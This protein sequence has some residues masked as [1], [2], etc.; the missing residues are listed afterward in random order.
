MFRPL[1]GHLQ[2]LWENRSKMYLY[3]NAL[4]DP[5]SLRMVFRN[6]ISQ[7]VSILDPTMHSEIDSSWI[8]LTRGLEDDL[9]KVETCRHDSKIFLFYIR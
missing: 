5:K 1:L 3:V 8:C 6:H 2:A 9:I 4:W 7:S